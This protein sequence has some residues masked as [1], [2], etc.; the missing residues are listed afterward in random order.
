MSR[1]WTGE[2]AEREMER[3]VYDRYLASLAGDNSAF[4]AAFRDAFFRA[5]RETLTQRQYKVL[6]MS[7]VEGLSGK[8]IA[9]K[10]GISAS[11]VSRHRT[12]GKKRLRQLLSYN[13]ELRS[14][15]FQ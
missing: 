9:G 8:E 10:L 6:W 15:P 14:R 7:E 12:R 2:P 13:L 3:A 5:M 4:R 11:A 1:I